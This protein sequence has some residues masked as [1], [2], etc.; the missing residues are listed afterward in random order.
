ML[1]FFLRWPSATAATAY[2][3][4]TAVHTTRRSPSGIV[5]VHFSAYDAITACTPNVV[6]H[7]H[8]LWVAQYCLV[9]HAQK[10]SM[11]VGSQVGGLV[12][13]CIGTTYYYAITRSLLLISMTLLMDAFSW[14]YILVHTFDPSSGYSAIL[15][16]R[17]HS[18]D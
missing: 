6:L 9:S 5:I 4:N 14:E 15:W 1:G 12:C 16:Y 8:I 7:S 11:N 3:T 17:K 18:S 2:R 13:F 10:L